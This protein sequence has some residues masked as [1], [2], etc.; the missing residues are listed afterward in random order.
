[1]VLRCMYRDELRASERR[2]WGVQRAASLRRSFSVALSSEL[3]GG[4]RR[5]SSGN[6][7]M[8]LRA[9]TPAGELARERTREP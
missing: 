2:P 1:M 3:S 6:R 8:Y 4:M 9:A 5:I 7:E